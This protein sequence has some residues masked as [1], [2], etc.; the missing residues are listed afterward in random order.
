MPITP[1]KAFKEK[2]TK[3]LI[4]LPLRT[5]YNRTFQCETPCTYHNRFLLKTLNTSYLTDSY[6]SFTL[7]LESRQNVCSNRSIRS[8]T[9]GKENISDFPPCG[10][11]VVFVNE[12]VI[13]L[14]TSK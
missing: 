11:L 7:N 9:Y 1:K 6:I 10:K 12:F 5:I 14:K 13:F 8:S 2:S 3:L 4:L